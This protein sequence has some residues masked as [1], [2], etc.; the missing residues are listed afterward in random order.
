MAM[1]A[2]VVYFVYAFTFVVKVNGTPLY[3]A[4]FVQ[5]WLVGL[6][7]ISDNHLHRAMRYYEC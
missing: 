3:A 1:V 6:L 5:V 4:N 7:L 2:A